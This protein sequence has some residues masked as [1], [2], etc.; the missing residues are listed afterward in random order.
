MLPVSSVGSPNSHIR[1]PVV[2][3]TRKLDQNLADDLGARRPAA[4]DVH[5]AGTQRGAIGEIG[6]EL[7]AALVRGADPP[8]GEGSVARD[9][10]MPA[11]WDL[12]R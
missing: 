4:Q 3:L 12:F 10:L 2:H 1:D 5:L 6:D 9:A 8:P 7:A 11:D